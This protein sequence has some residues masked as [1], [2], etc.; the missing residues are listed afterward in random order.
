MMS[1]GSIIKYGL[2]DGRPLHSQRKCGERT[3]QR[4]EGQPF[5][6]PELKVAQTGYC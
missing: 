3:G 4:C 5:E 6:M 1:V 2:K